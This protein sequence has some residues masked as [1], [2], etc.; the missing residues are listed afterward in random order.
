MSE[1]LFSRAVIPT[2][3]L[4]LIRE[5]SNIDINDLIYYAKGTVQLLGE[6]FKYQKHPWFKTIVKTQKNGYLSYNRDSMKDKFDIDAMIE[7]SRED[8]FGDIWL[9]ELRLRIR[10]RSTPF[11][12]IFKNS[13]L[14]PG[15]EAETFVIRYLIHLQRSGFITKIHAR[16]LPLIEC[17]SKPRGAHLASEDLG[18][19]SFIKWLSEVTGGL[20]KMKTVRKEDEETFID[21][22]ISEAMDGGK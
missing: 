21:V 22:R 18:S 8:G 12:F 4:F 19:P 17:L 14:T 11:D 6:S 2:N 5:K 3:S 9:K 13:P 10:Y 7:L 20:V 1:I 16:H 15:S